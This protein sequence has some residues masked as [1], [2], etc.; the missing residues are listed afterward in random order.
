MKIL[1]AIKRV[2]DYNIKVG[3]KADGSNVD[4][5][6][7]KM[8]ANPFDENAIEQAIRLKEQ[9]KATEIVA[10][11]I[12]SAANQDVLRHALAMGVD[13]AVLVEHEAE[14]QSLEVA[15]LLKVI[16]EQEQPDLIILGKQAVDDDA[17]Q[18]GQM[19]AALLNY[20]QGTFA[21]ALDIEANKAIVTREVD[22]GTETLALQLP[23][24]VTA[25]LRLNDPRFVKL[26][27]LM[28]ARKKPIETL[29]AADLVSDL[30]ARLSLLQVAEPPARKPGIK[31]DSVDA[32]LQQ[33]RAKEGIEL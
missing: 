24:V 9:G 31:V 32:L 17:G 13:R 27:N 19:L 18:A 4:I 22:G 6:G 21:S 3:I 33:L 2:V 12:G 26:P 8:S 23:A 14:V 15:K 11:S 10:V 7:V 30:S 16:V 28:Q 5:D 29:V 1:V 20:P 25:D